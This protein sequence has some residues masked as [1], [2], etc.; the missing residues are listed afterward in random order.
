MA[1]PQPQATTPPPL[2]LIL[3][4]ASLKISSDGTIANLQALDCVTT[5]LEL[6]PDTTV[7]TV[8][9]MCGSTDYAGSTKWTL[10]ATLVQS[11]DA[12]ATEDILSAAVAGGV[13][14]AFE[15]LPYKSKAV[16]ATNPAWTGLVNP[17]PYPPVNGDA[18][19]QSE[20]S[21]EWGVVGA[22]TKNI[23][24]PVAPLAEE[25]TT[26]GSKSGA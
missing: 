25:T 9:T 1:T 13:P 20:I 12:G 21:L 18:G 2:P 19:A 23:T 7:T 3:T 11:L 5:H 4:D 26:A 15:I 6:S 17:K 22:P 8:D 16:G 24:T 14:V 10:I